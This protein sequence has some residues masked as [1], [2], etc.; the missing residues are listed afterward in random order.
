LFGKN[1]WKS[2]L[3]SAFAGVA[4]LA[5]SFAAARAGESALFANAPFFGLISLAFAPA[6]LQLCASALLAMQV[7]RYKFA[8]PLASAVLYGAVCLIF[9]LD[10]P[11][12]ALAAF[13]PLLLSALTAGFMLNLRAPLFRTV[14]LCALFFLAASFAGLGFMNHFKQLDQFGEAIFQMTEALGAVAGDALPSGQSAALKENLAA[15]AR[16]LNA[17]LPSLFLCF[18]LSYA[19]L[20]VVLTKRAL[21]KSGRD[22]AYLT[23]FY[24]LRFDMPAAVGFLALLFVAPALESQLARDLALNVL[25]I[26]GFLFFVFGTSLAAW[27]MKANGV[28]KPLRVAALAALFVSPALIPLLPP[29]VLCGVGVLDAFFNFRTRKSVS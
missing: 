8:W 2:Y 5:A 19:Y 22:M 7:C 11:L 14:A 27:K 4:C 20:L 17:V 1:V 21:V 24:N 28:G 29:L 15:F 10:A 18:G 25:A 9:S 13:A 23:N 26:A 3:I 12:L 6:A 16:L